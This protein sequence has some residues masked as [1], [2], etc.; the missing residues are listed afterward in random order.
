MRQRGH[1]KIESGAESA[2]AAAAPQ[3]GQCRLP[4]NINAKQDGQATVASFDSQY[5][6]RGESD[7]IAAPQFGQFRVS[8]CMTERASCVVFASVLLAQVRLSRRDGIEIFFVVG[9]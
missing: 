5:R 3:C 1:F 4:A 2:W 6:Q 7:E 9:E 8:A